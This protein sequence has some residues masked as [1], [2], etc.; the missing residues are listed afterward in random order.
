MLYA[1]KFTKI[2]QKA[3][4]QLYPI[5]FVLAVTLFSGL[6]PCASAQ[7]PELFSPSNITGVP[8]TSHFY[9]GVTANEG[10]SFDSSFGF[11]QPIDIRGEI[12][13]EVPHINSVGNLYILI[14][15]GELIFQRNGPQIYEI[16]DGTIEG[17]RPAVAAK[18]LQSTE[19][20][21]VVDNLPFGPVGISNAGLNVF[22]A[23]DTAAAPG[24]LYFNA[25]PL[26]LFIQA[27]DATP[28]SEALFLESVSAPV[29]Q[30]R[31][32][33][34]HTSPGVA[35]ASGLIYQSSSVPGY[36]ATNYL[37]LVN[38]INNT[39]NG[40][41]R[42]MAKP[43][44]QDSHGGGVI[45]SS[46]S[47]SN[48]LNLLA[49]LGA[50]QTEA[51]TGVTTTI[52]SAIFD[53]V[54]AMDNEETLR[55]AALLFAG[56][57]PTELETSTVA[58]GGDAE[59]RSGIRSVMQGEGFS[60]FLLDGAN[61]QLLTEAFSG[62]MFDI[63][64]RKYYPNSAIYFQNPSLRARAITIASAL[65]EEPLRLIEYIVQQERP[66]TEVLTADYTLMNPYAAE[67]YNSSLSFSDPED[68]NEWQP[69]QITDYF[70]CSICKQNPPD[71]IFDIPTDYPHAGLLNSPAFLSRYPS[72]ATNRNRA[73]SRWAYYY[74][75]GV[76]IEGIADRTT[77]QD[78]L[79]DENNPT[80]NNPNCI[81]CHDIM[82]PVAG[83]FQNYNDDGFYRSRPGGTDSL[84][85]SYKSSANSG[86][87][88]GDTW[89]SDMLAPGFGSQFAPN[90]E[91][92]IQWLGQEFTKDSRFG[93][94]TVNF[95]YP[96]VMGRLPYPEP[97][98]Q[99]DINYQSKLAAYAQ[100]QKMLK[101]VASNFVS[102][103]AGRGQHNLKDL[104]VDLVMA[105]HFRSSSVSQVSELQAIELAEIG[106]GKL[107]TPEQLNRKLSS[108][109]G[110]EWNYGRGDALEEV[111]GLI[112]GGIDSLGITERAT[113]LTTLMS[114]VVTTMANET[115]CSITN[116]DFTR[117]KDSRMLFPFIELGS[118]PNNASVA[119]RSNIQFLHKQLLGEPLELDSAE[120]DATYA[121]FAE[122]LNARQAANKPSAVSSAAELCIFENVPNAIQNDPNQTL[123]SWAVVI[124]YLM[125][126]YRFIH[127]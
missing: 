37:T 40:A 15:L 126:D 88:S 72:T 6:L 66:Y 115:A 14:A 78:A 68:F 47:D 82:D 94:G 59:L 18:T 73:R 39:P 49:F 111:Y 53:S 69:A 52:A 124:N 30:A 70:R 87:Q 96:S 125:R 5:R 105:D 16:W 103:A 45:Y 35:E 9:G 97:E 118:T 102:G 99:E 2:N 3:F 56:R 7:L 104:L 54:I 43:L 84:P 86:Y 62:G 80:L 123:R 46:S 85:A 106:K 51:L 38:Y 75:L 21:T 63:V 117:P 61:D 122:I 4:H 67:I 100:E 112:Y 83:A 76:D 42:L 50:V 92:S 101:E 127:E 60:K 48:Y 1:K 11:S 121:L 58:S 19:E 24:E 57:L 71:I 22:F 27:Q 17:L 8:T 91:N 74:F 31:C 34:C 26:S 23:Y 114:T 20:I 12:Q 120:V 109:L 95:W 44:G 33:V 36:Q 25:V 119:I 65:A 113:E 98:N 90:A 32:V 93:F 28:A 79:Q 110:F 116:L 13:V 107:L 29:V 10:V 89:Y 55:K 41:A 77:D 64:N 108:V 81:V